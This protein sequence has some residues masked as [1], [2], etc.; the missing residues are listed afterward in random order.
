M[1]QSHFVWLQ[2]IGSLSGDV[3]RLICLHFRCKPPIYLSWVVKSFP[4]TGSNRWCCSDSPG[5]TIILVLLN[6]TVGTA[7]VLLRGTS[8]SKALLLE[9]SGMQLKV[10]LLTLIPKPEPQWIQW[11]ICSE[12][13]HRKR[14]IS[15]RFKLLQAELRKLETHQWRVWFGRGN[16]CFEVWLS[17]GHTQDEN[18]HCWVNSTNVV[19]LFANHPKYLAKPIPK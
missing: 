5:I 12:F 4:L 3:P 7:S 1:V 9:S 8:T 14:W 6:V 11:E 10:P 15:F 13:G 19:D 16:G 17:F 18:V 2:Q